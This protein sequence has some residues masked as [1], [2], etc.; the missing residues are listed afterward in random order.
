MFRRS[1]TMTG[2]LS[3]TVKSATE[4]SATLRSERLKHHDL[5]ATRRRIVGLLL[6]C[7]V[8]IGVLYWLL[9]QFISSVKIV[10][11]PPAT[12]DASSTYQHAI[13]SYFHSRPGER[14][15]VT[16]NTQA[17]TAAVQAEY[18][19]VR[20]ITMHSD[21]FLVPSVATVSL[22]TAIAVWTIQGKKYYIDEHGVAFT[23]TPQYEP[24]LV[25][26]DNTGIDP[27][28]T[29]ALASERMLHYIGRIVALVQQNNFTVNKLELPADTSRQVNIYLEG[30]GYP[31]KT[32]LDRDPAAQAQD[33]INALRYIDTRAISPEYIDVRVS[34]KAFYK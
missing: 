20:T 9:G 17:L 32:H 19:E 24:S 1:R 10:T 18:P 6:G 14:F 28:D 29:G 15:H 33:V 30:R 12:A 16:V 13:Q 4:Q 21:G 26:E 22:R 2:S 8:A 27:A 5:R 7:L 11:E 25:V 23:R 34:S 3:N 31:I